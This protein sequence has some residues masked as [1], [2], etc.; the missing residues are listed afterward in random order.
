[1]KKIQFLVIVCGKDSIFDYGVRKIYHCLVI[2]CGKDS[3]FGYSI[4]ERFS[5]WV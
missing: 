2:I 5:F 4:L 3:V 1:M